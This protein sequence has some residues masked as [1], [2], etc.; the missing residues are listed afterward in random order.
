MLRVK[1]NESTNLSF[2]MIVEGNAKSID[3]TWIVLESDGYELRFPAAYAD[4]KVS[5]TIPAL[6]GILANG[7]TTAHLEVVID[8]RYYRPMSESIVVG[9]GK[10]DISVIA[11]DTCDRFD[12]SF[13]ALKKITPAATGLSTM[14][15]GDFGK[16]LES[17]LAEERA[18]HE[19]RLADARK[20]ADTLIRGITKTDDLELLRS[21][22]STNK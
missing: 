21:R 11:K 3:K 14:E 18:S 5:C 6:S 1:L 10:Q 4:G 8:G 13:A 9:S 7:S 17:K 2:D 19:R 22:I 12:A 20:I 15:V 16:Q